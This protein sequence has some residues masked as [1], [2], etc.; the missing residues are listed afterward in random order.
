M[1]GSPREAPPRGARLCEACD[2]RHTYR[3]PRER[4]VHSIYVLTTPA[5]KEQLEPFYKV[6]KSQRRRQ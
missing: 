2:E 4:L 1:R 5:E 6:L 3:G